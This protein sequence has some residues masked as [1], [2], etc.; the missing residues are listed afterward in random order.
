MRGALSCGRRTAGVGKLPRWGIAYSTRLG[1]DF[2]AVGRQVP[3]EETPSF[4]RDGLATLA[5]VVSQIYRV[6]HY[7]FGHLSGWAA[8]VSPALAE[9]VWKVQK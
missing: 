9:K 5:P 4:R 7:T 6:H 2:I 1:A 8:A 3:L